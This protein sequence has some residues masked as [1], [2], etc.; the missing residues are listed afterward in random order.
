MQPCRLSRPPA[1]AGRQ[2]LTAPLLPKPY[3]YSLISRN[4]FSGFLISGQVC[5]QH[6]NPVLNRWNWCDRAL[7]DHRCTVFL[8][9]LSSWCCAAQTQNGDTLPLLGTCD[10]KKTQVLWNRKQIW[11]AWCPREYAAHKSSKGSRNG[12]F[13][14]KKTRS[15]SARCWWILII[16]GGGASKKKQAPVPDLTGTNAAKFQETKVWKD[17]KVL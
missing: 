7:S 11:I 4:F 1:P 2:P 17:F 5:P 14:P 15:L 10:V 6:G 8:A 12:C 16:M 13:R 9:G 3:F